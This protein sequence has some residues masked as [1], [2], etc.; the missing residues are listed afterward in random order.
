[1]EARQYKANTRRQDVRRVLWQWGDTMRLCKRKMEEIAALQAMIEDARQLGAIPSDGMPKS[2]TVGDPT[3]GAAFRVEK[4]IESFGDGMVKIQESIDQAMRLKTAIDELLHD[5]PPEQQKV[6]E[7]RY[8]E[9]KSWML[10]GFK[11]NA[12]EDQARKWER[13]AIDKIADSM[14]VEQIARFYPL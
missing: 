6:L 12:H 14:L 9:G 4:I 13:Q 8:V 2:T 5:L 11:V 3:A 10:V 7:L 1:M